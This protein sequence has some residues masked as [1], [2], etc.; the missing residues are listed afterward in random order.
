MRYQSAYVP[1]GNG[2]TEWCHRTDKRI[3]TR[4]RRSIAEAVY[5]Y[6][7]T[8][9][10]NETPSRALAN[11]IYQYEQRVKGV[12]PKPSPP[13]DRSNVYQIG[14]P[15]WVKPPDCQC[16]TRFYKGQVD[17]VTVL[18]QWHTPPCERPSQMR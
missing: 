15:V 1:E 8:P 16:T 14:K 9:K 7:A 3:A 17:G 11:G 5:W 6:N 13:E 4:S 18:G 12:D 2:I 10:D